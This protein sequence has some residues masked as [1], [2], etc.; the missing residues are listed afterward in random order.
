M[1]ARRAACRPGLCKVNR[2]CP[3]GRAASAGQVAQQLL[4]NG[5]V[6]SRLAAV[7]LAQH[8][9]RLPGT[10]AECDKTWRQVGF[11]NKLT[12]VFGSSILSLCSLRH[13]HGD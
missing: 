6:G 8:R 12:P 2:T 3:P 5:R 7:R 13:G 9:Q 1:R 10:T 4:R 11:A